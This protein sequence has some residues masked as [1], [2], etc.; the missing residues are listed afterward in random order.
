MLDCVVKDEGVAC[1]V[2][3]LYIF[4]NGAVLFPDMINDWLEIQ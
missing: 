2:T 3:G 4:C 1:A